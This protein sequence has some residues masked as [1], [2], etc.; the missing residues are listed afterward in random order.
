MRVLIADDD[1]TARRMLELVLGKLG[2]EIVAVAN[3]EAALETLTGEDAPDIAILDWMMPRLSG[4]QVCK[5][6]RQRDSGPYIYVVMLTSMSGSQ[7]IVRGLEAGADDYMT[8]PFN[9]NELQARLRSG[10]RVVRLHHEL[11]A[12][13]E[14]IVQ[15]TMTAARPMAPPPLPIRNHGINHSL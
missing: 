12:A 14:E 13:K 7:D 10:E 11:R 4:D 8:K 2:H 9:I 1:A 15:L 5:Q 6:L 3:G